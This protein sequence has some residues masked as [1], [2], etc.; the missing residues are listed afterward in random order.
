MSIR[1][2]PE[3]QVDRGRT[4]LD[5]VE[6]TRPL[7]NFYPFAAEY[8]SGS[9]RQPRSAGGMGTTRLTVSTMHGAI[10]SINVSVAR[11]LLDF[12]RA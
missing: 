3:R 1:C 10:E 4:L 2:L 8:L 6:R 7:L 9:P 5:T 11:D 12:D